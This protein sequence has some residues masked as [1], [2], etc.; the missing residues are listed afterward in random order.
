MKKLILG[1]ALLVTACTDNPV[2]VSKDNMLPIEEA[3]DSILYYE[4]DEDK[5]LLW[6]D[7]LTTLVWEHLYNN[8]DYWEY[9]PT[10]ELLHNQKFMQCM[11]DGFDGLLGIEDST[12]TVSYFY[13]AYNYYKPEY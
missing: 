10:D 2:K 3:C 6:Y 11:Q 12:G 8:G 9:N 7:S 4:N 1:A 13:G 5:L